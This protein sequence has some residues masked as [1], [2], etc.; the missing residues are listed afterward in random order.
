[1]ARFT[2]R[3]V[4]L[5]PDESALQV[6][7][8]LDAGV[9]GTGIGRPSRGRRG[10]GRAGRGRGCR[11][12]RRRR[13]PRPCC[14]HR[15]VPVRRNVGSRASA[16]SE[17]MRT[18]PSA[19]LTRRAPGAVVGT[20]SIVG[21][22]V[23]AVAELGVAPGE[24]ARADDGA[25]VGGQA[26]RRRGSSRRAVA[27]PARCARAR[28]ARC[29]P[30]GL[31]GQRAQQPVELGDQQRR[32]QRRRSRRHGRP[33]PGGRCGPWRPLPA[34]PRRTGPK[35]AGRSSTR[36]AMRTSP[37]ARSCDSPAFQ[38][39]QCS[40][41]RMPCPSPPSTASSSTT[42]PPDGRSGVDR[43]HHGDRDTL[44]R[45]RT[46]APAVTA[47][48]SRPT[49]LVAARHR[50]RA[51]RSVTDM[52]PTIRRGCDISRR[53]PKVVGGR[54]RDCAQLAASPGSDSGPAVAGDSVA[55]L[56]AAPPTPA[57][58]DVTPARA[59]RPWRR[60]AAHRR[61]RCGARPG[62][63]GARSAARRGGRA[64]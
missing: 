53:P 23:V 24:Q 62:R 11:R 21:V 41:E 44:G 58:P 45:P 25:F 8:D 50:R 54:S 4:G 30:V 55:R 7:D 12:R 61:S 37:S 48:R 52:A 31:L 16:A 38:V 1:M 29:R 60:C 26:E 19:Q 57:G 49:T 63:R 9:A 59:G 13:G 35:H 33:G 17:A 46:H 14:V 64:R 34:G 32:R 6:G 22:E 3:S 47:P 28:A 51:G 5:M 10:P 42:A 27:T 15:A 40:G 2:V 39:T 56:A 36:R 20:S 18:S 43:T